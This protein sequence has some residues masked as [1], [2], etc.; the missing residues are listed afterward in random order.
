MFVVVLS[1]NV[2]CVVGFFQMD[3]RREHAGGSPEASHIGG[4]WHPLV[5]VDYDAVEQHGHTPDCYTVEQVSEALSEVIR[6]LINDGKF[7]RRGI[8]H[9]AITL[10]FILQPTFV[11]I[12]TQTEL[13]KR[14]GLSEAQT[15]AFVK[16][17]TDRFGFMAQHLRTHGKAEPRGPSQG[18]A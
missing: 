1:I 16:S 13:A 3:D 7:Q 17:F 5:P 8:Y 12:T 11:G 4:E 10:A 2:P 18:G 9:R 14:L 15:S 6:W